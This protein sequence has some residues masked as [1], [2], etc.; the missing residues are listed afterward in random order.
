MTTA[1]SNLPRQPMKLRQIAEKI[2]LYA[3]I[4]FVSAITFFP[5]YW[6][7][8]STLQ[9]NKYTLN[10][11]PPFFPQEI[12]LT[13]FTQLFT[14]RPI[15]LWLGNSFAVATMSM[16]IAMSVTVL[17]AYAL[18]SLRWK[19]RSAFGLF[20]LIT[21]MLPEILVLIPL[22]VLYSRLDLLDKQFTVAMIDAAF[23]IPVCIWILKGVFDGVPPEVLD[24]AL[25]DGCTEIS[26]LF[27]I[28]LPLSAPG[29]VAVAVVSFFA[30][31]NEY[32][33]ANIML[34][35]ASNMVASVGLTTLKGLSGV[36]VEQWM[37][38]GFSF[39]ILPVIFYLTMQRY[40]ITGL[41]A[42]AVKG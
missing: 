24:A 40:I 37:A 18:S 42:G 36:L 39:S 33:Y 27:R 15:A 4:I 32:L 3:A 13:Q 38:A 17:G 14:E 8:V 9:P 41:T 19:G 22:Y 16:L 25:V 21:Q 34:T 35:S 26:T 29:L 30:G 28:V 12:T 2:A 20:L 10:F 6:M 23:A 31:W 5:I 7:L 1:V 11:P